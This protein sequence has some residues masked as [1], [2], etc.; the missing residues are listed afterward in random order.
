MQEAKLSNFFSGRF[1]RFFPDFFHVS[2]THHT[3]LSRAAGCGPLNEVAEPRCEEQGGRGLLPEMQE[4]KLSNFFF[5]QE[6]RF[7]LDFFDISLTPYAC[8]CRPT[9]SVGLREGRSSRRLSSPDHASE[10]KD[11]QLD[12]IEMD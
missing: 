2:Q 1:F 7:F 11:A 9:G 8:R 6:F 10:A 4:A 5:G 12:A 3:C